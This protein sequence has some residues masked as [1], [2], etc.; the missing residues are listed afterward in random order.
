[1]ASLH[2]H[3]IIEECPASRSS[4]FLFFL[5]SS[6]SAGRRRSI[7][8]WWA[9]AL[10]PRRQICIRKDRNPSN[11]NHW[12]AKCVD[13][14]LRLYYTALPPPQQQYVPLFF[15]LIEEKKRKEVFL[16]QMEGGYPAAANE[17]KRN[18]SNKLMQATGERER[19]GRQQTD[20]VRFSEDVCVYCV[21]VR[22]CLYNGVSVPLYYVY[23]FIHRNGAEKGKGGSQAGRQ[24][25]K[26][27]SSKRSDYLSNTKK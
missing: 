7:H 23:I 25:E 27:N 18:D 17:W 11:P 2:V 22:T 19:E 16:F 4:V 1:M 8:L 26:S 14:Y 9:P 5:L 15:F 20:D 3:T 12:W 24:A 6:L 21:R 13:L 10:L